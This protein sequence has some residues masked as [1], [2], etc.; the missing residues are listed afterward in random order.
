MNTEIELKFLVSPEFVSNLPTLLTGYEIRQYDQK[1]L[2]NTYFDTPDLALGKL[3]AG[4]RVRDKNGKLEQ[5][6]KLAGSQVAG[7]HQRPEYNLDL[8]VPEPDLSQFPSDIWPADFSVSQ[9]QADLRPLFSTDFVR[10]RWLVV[11]N[12]TEIELALDRGQ[13][14]AGLQQA[15]IQELELELVSGEVAGLFALAEQLLSQGGLRLSDVSKAQRGYQLAGLAAG[16][17]LQQLSFSGHRPA[18]DKR[19]LLALLEQGVEHWQHHEQGVLMQSVASNEGEKA[20]WL[21]QVRAGVELVTQTLV[22][23]KATSRIPQ[24]NLWL[25]DLAWLQA[26]LL[27]D[28]GVEALFYSA[29]YGRLLLQLAHYLYTQSGH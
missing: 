20:L 26:Q 24:L 27:T 23:L 16:P 1:N 15:A 22:S 9:V 29:R 28:T 25:D 13:V 7:L 18:Q 11:V 4:L 8:T 2:K 21:A 10:E 14:R 17:Q 6:V 5:T 12:H 19:A 3:K